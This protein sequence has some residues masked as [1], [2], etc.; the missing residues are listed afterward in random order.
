M[1]SVKVKTREQLRRWREKFR[2]NNLYTRYRIT[3]DQYDALFAWQNNACAG[4]SMT[5]WPAGRAP[6]IDHDHA[7]C[8]RVDHE[9]GACGK[10]IRGILCDPCNLRDVLAGAPHVDWQAVMAAWVAKGRPRRAGGLA[11]DTLTLREACDSGVLPWGYEAAKKRLQRKVGQVPAP[12]DR[13]G[14]ADAYRVEDLERWV[15]SK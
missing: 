8:P 13:K 9:R 11:G 10:C 12:R 3:I 6:A 7:C 4:C 2:R 15:A 5:R 14:N 1:G